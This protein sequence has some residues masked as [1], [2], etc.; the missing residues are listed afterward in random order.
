MYCISSTVT[1]KSSRPCHKMLLCGYLLHSVLFVVPNW[2]IILSILLFCKYNLFLIEWVSWVFQSLWLALWL[3]SMKRSQQFL[4]KY[5]SSYSC[6]TLTFTTVLLLYNRSASSSSS[7]LSSL[8]F[9]F[10]SVLKDGLPN[11]ALSSIPHLFHSVLS[12]ATFP[13]PPPQ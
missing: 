7:P 10:H 1:H 8:Q 11:T 6:G 4:N 5:L 13:S 2:R 3:L 12:D 9:N